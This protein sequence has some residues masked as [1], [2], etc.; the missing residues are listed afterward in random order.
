MTEVAFAVRNLSKTFAPRGEGGTPRTVID[1]LNLTIRKQEFICILGPSGCGKSSFLNILSGLDPDY[2]GELEVNGNKIQHGRLPLQIGYL[3]QEPRLL[4]WLTAEANVDFVLM[5][6]AKPQERWAELKDKYFALAGLEGFRNHYPHQ[7]SGGMCQ[8]L[9]LVRA[10][11]VEPEILLM[12][13]PFSGLDELTGRRMRMDLVDIW[14]KTGKT[15][16]FVTHNSYEATFLA[17]RILVMSKGQVQKEIVID[18]PRP[19]DYDHPSMFEANRDVLRSFLKI[20]E[21]AAAF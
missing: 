13:E 1:G 2:D 3:F 17:D 19:R 15:I 4:P 20:A 14:R 7:M 16:I 8:R 21:D 5:A 18:V 6:S 11:C 12:D 10:L 9:A